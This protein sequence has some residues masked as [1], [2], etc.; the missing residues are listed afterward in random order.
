MASRATQRS[1][2]SVA[3]SSIVARRSR[4]QTTSAVRGRGSRMRRARISL[5]RVTSAEPMGR[6]HPTQTRHVFVLPRLVLSSHPVD[7][8]LRTEM[9]IA[10]T[11]VQL[12]YAVF[13]PLGH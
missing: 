9:E 4:S 3:P 13:L 7:V 1:A 5:A 2:S 10:N 12:G 11:L 8:G 6:R